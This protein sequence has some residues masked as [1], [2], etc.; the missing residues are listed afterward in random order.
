MLQIKRGKLEFPDASG[1]KELKREFAESSLVFL[2]QFL[3]PSILNRLMERLTTTD[4]VTK[5]EMSGREDF[6]KTMFVPETEPVL[7]TFHLLLNNPQLFGIVEEITNC[8]AI[9]NFSGRMHRSQAGGNHSIDW[10]GDNADYRMI[11]LTVDL[12]REKYTGGK[13]QLRETATGKILREIG[14]TRAGDA[15]LFRI[16][17]DLQHRLTTLVSGGDRSVGVGWFRSAPD[18]KTFAKD[19]FQR[20]VI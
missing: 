20:S 17:P 5:Y 4:F 7:F 10:H 12:S 3:E 15:F 19:Y 6:G 16:S 11:G 13:F 14:D 8:G 2:P 1:I 9:G 18:W